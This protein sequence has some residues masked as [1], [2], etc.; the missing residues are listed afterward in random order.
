MLGLTSFSFHILAIGELFQTTYEA[1]ERTW[2][3]F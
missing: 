3:F 1:N 2:S